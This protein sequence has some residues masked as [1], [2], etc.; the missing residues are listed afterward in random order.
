MASGDFVCDDCGVVDN[1]HSTKQ[2][3]SGYHCSQCQN[4]TWHNEFK[5][6]H[7]DPEY[8]HDVLNRTGYR[9]SFS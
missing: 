6:E 5:M 2:N 1:I 9:P 7:Y 8:H 3:S 4:G